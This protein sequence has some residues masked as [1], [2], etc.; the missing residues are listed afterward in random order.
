MSPLFP[1]T[2]KFERLRWV[3]ESVRPLDIEE[4]VFCAVVPG[5]GAFCLE[6]NLLTGNC[7]ACGAGGQWGKLAKKINAQE[8][9][10]PFGTDASAAAMAR[11]ARALTKA[12]VKEHKRDRAK[13]FTKP[14]VSEW[15]GNWRGFRGQWLR[16]QGC[17]RVDDLRSNVL[18]IGLPIRTM[19]GALRAYTCRAIEPEDATPKY[20]PLHA[21]RSGWHDK[22][23]PANDLF[24][25]GEK[26]LRYGWKRVVLVEGPVDAMRL[27]S[28]GVPALAILGVSNWGPIKRDALI[29]AGVTHF[30]V[31]M[32]GDKAGQEAQVQILESLSGCN[33][34]G[35]VLP[36]DKDPGKMSDKQIAFLQKELVNM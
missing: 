11:V 17:V 13:D 20:A 24:F 14:L 34:M 2:T 9:P 10:T 31:L 19:S 23:L 7:F 3:V 12:G 22:E 33:A 1:Q 15:R 16:D 36:P 8:V 21:D 29:A 25:N 30:L 32:D 5:A 35:L 28:L 18:R 6:G 4:E 27:W 26:V